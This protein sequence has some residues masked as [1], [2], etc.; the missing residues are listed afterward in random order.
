MD[1]SILSW[2]VH[3]LPRPFDLHFWPWDKTPRHHE[4]VRNIL[5]RIRSLTPQPDVIAFQ[6]VWRDDDAR[7]L[8]GLAGY[9][10]CEAPN[11]PIM[12]PTG[13]LTLCRT[14]RWTFLSCDAFRYSQSANTDTRGK[15]GLLLNRLQRKDGQRITIIN[16]HLQSQ[17]ATEGKKTYKQIRQSQIGELTRHARDAVARAVPLIAVGDFNTYPYPSDDDVYELISNG[18]PWLDLTQTSRARCGCETNFDS[19]RKGRMDGWI[20]YA[21]AFADP[22]LTFKASVTLLTNWQIDTPYSDHQGL[23]ASI[24]V[25]PAPSAAALVV[26]AALASTTPNRREWLTILG[27]AIAKALSHL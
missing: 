14:D 2:N 17:Y 4:R 10:A 27:A 18:V 19:T 21:L 1:V 16:T 12:R 15:K 8:M 3:G 22:Q 6:E 13:L 20:D 9:T 26:G 11:G 7:A 24:T 5:G 23:F 25:S